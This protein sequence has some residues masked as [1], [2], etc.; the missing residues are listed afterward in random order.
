[1]FLIFSFFGGILLSYLMSFTVKEG[2]QSI[3]ISILSFLVL[4]I[5]LLPLIWGKTWVSKSLPF[6]A[7]MLFS[8]AIF[9]EMNMYNMLNINY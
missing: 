7:F 8:I 4:P 2:F 1:M 3:V 6:V 9:Q 5:L